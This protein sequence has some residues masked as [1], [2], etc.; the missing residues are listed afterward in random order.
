MVAHL[1]ELEAA[2]QYLGEGS[3]RT[4]SW[5][6]K[7]VLDTNHHQRTDKL[8]MAAAP[9]GEMSEVSRTVSAIHHEGEKMSSPERC[10]DEGD[11]PDTTG[12][13]SGQEPIAL[14][15]ETE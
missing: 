3:A 9:H 1:V 4:C 12:I 11:D 8:W 10:R 14:S 13:G 6:L 7:P 5:A 2:F 15:L